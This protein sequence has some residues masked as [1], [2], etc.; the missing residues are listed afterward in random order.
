[1]VQGPQA[2][3]D[4]FTGRRLALDDG[5]FWRPNADPLQA[6]GNVVTDDSCQDSTNGFGE[7]VE[8]EGIQAQVLKAEVVPPI[9][10]AKVGG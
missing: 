10:D 8:Q 6:D 2:R 9:E 5:S 3:P 4:L 1:M 7:K